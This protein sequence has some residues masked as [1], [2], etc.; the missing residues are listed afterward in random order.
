[1][2]GYALWFHCGMFGVQLLHHPKVSLA[3]PQ[4]SMLASS[5]RFTR[6]HLS[7]WIRICSS[8]ELKNAVKTEAAGYHE[9]EMQAKGSF[10]KTK[11]TISQAT[12]Y[13]MAHY[14]QPLP[15][16]VFL[17]RRRRLLG[18]THHRADVSSNS[19]EAFVFGFSRGPNYSSKIKTSTH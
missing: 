18:A 5:C 11:H 16:G 13:L 1:M 15:A 2:S 8:A 17:S 4:S 10:L 19:N 14:S 7:A 9:D 3:G 12:R 6:G